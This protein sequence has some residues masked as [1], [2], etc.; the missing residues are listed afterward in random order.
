M[1][2]SKKDQRAAAAA[3]LR[4]GLPL[5]PQR[6]ARK[7]ASRVG[8]CERVATYRAFEGQ[9]NDRLPNPRVKILATL[10]PLPSELR[11]SLGRGDTVS[12]H[13]L[14][15]C[16]FPLRSYAW[17]PTAVGRRCPQGRRGRRVRGLDACGYD[18]RSTLLAKIGHW[19]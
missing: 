2:F 1:G 5:L 19:D 16:I 4:W 13:A 8:S 3:A 15:C 9:K 18:R 10:S 7:E 12:G 6:L 17:G 11:G 14:T